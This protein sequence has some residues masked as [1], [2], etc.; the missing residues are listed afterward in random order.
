MSIQLP[1]SRNENI[2]IHVGGELLPR[3][4]A[5][6]S[7]FDSAVQG[8][9]AVWEGLR[10]YNGKIFQL[11]AHLDRLFD[12]AKAM[13]F[14]DIPS[15]EAIKT[16]IFETLKTN[17]MRDEV[18][19]R[20]TLTRGKKTS[21]GMSPH[22]NQYGSCLIVLPEWKPPVYSSDGIRLITASVR[23]NPPMCI[24]S[25]IH[26]NNLIN[27]I[28]AKIEANVA[29]VDD[30]IMLDIFG[31]VSETNATN[32]FIIKKGALITPH[33]D[34]CLPGITRGVVIDLARDLGIK[35]T[36]RNLSLTEVYTA[37]ESFT[38][39]TM[40][41][42]S[43]ILEVDGRTIGNGEPGPVTNRLRQQYA[44]HTAEHGDPIP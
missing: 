32:I 9:D 22:F 14:A 33:A 34:S 17:N 30:A 15:R 18:H 28:L 35:V 39:G 12:S 16:A 5:K 19:I 7:V 20:L 23:R 3:E 25:K 2:L 41:E 43:P 37:D 27:N 42:L 11:D 1:D 44:Q 31:Y 13:A 29:G 38:T 40:G 24:D 36:E 4:D 6:I 21:S 26:H 8:G 10:V